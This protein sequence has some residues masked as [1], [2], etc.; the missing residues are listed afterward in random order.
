MVEWKTKKLK[1]FILIRVKELSETIVLWG[2]G[3]KVKDL[4][5]YEHF[6]EKPIYE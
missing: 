3:E 2:I 1:L 5:F 4:S 6:L